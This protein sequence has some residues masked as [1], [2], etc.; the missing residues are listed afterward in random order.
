KDIPA[1]DVGTSEREMDWMMGEYKSIHPGQKYRGSFTG[2]SVGNGG[3]LGRKNATGK[4]VYFSFRYLLH[5]FIEKQYKWLEERENIFAKTVLEYYDK[6]LK[7]AVQGFG[8]VGSVVALEAHN[9][10]VL[11]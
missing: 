1:P 8:N 3:S 2:K 11:N 6:P 7:I 5:D 10:N 4:G 9:C